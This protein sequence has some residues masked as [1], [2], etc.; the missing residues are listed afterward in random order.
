MKLMRR[1]VVKTLQY[2]TLQI[3][4]YPRCT[5]CRCWSPFSLVGPGLSGSMHKYGSNAISST[6]NNAR[7]LK[8]IASFI[9]KNSLSTASRAA[10]AKTFA[11]YSVSMSS[12]FPNVPLLPPTTEHLAH[13]IAFCFRRNIAALTLKSH[14][15]ALSYNFEIKG[16]DQVWCRWWRQRGEPVCKINVA[17]V[18]SESC[19]LDPGWPRSI[20]CSRTERQQGASWQSRWAG[21]NR[22]RASD[23][24]VMV[25]WWRWVI[26]NNSRL[27]AKSRAFIITAAVVPHQDL[28]PTLPYPRVS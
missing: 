20:R 1:F 8:D 7:P 10:Y 15:S 28:A 26:Q 5:K 11:F 22:Q 19:L 9:L 18:F 24:I 13:F 16:G 27:G 21:K 12:H 25:S 17:C 23:V 2:N 6:F 4:T 3:N 14:I